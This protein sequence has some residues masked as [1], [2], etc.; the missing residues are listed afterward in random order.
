M[1]AEFGSAKEALPLSTVH[2]ENRFP[3]AGVA[4]I[5]YGVDGSILTVP[6]GVVEPLPLLLTVNVLCGGEYILI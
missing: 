4:M 1:L 2:E 5:E 6:A 3:P